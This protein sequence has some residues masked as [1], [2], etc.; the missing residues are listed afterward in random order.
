MKASIKRASIR[1]AKSVK[2][3]PMESQELT[4]TSEP[5]LRPSD[6]SIR[7]RAYYNTLGLLQEVCIL[8]GPVSVNRIV[9]QVFGMAVPHHTSLTKLTITRGKLAPIVLVEIGKLL[10]LS[11]L[12]EICLDDTHVPQKNYATL[13]QNGHLLRNLSLKRCKLNDNTCKEIAASIEIG[14]PGATLQTLELSS[15]SISDEGAVAFANVLRRNRYLLHLNLSGNYITDEGAAAILKV[16]MEFPMTQNEILQKRRNFINFAKR[17]IEIYDR[18]LLEMKISRQ[19]PD[20]RTRSNSRTKSLRSGTGSSK[21]KGSPSKKSDK[22]IPDTSLE[23]P[24][25]PHKMGYSHPELEMKARETVGE[26]FDPF[27]ADQTVL[28]EN[29]FYCVGN[30]FFCSLNLAYNNLEYSSVKLINTVL[31]YQSKVKRSPAAPGL[32]RISF[33]GNLVPQYC[34][35]YIFIELWLQNAI[36]NHL[37]RTTTTIH[38]KRVPGQRKSSG[39]LL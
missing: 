1:S 12:V 2:V 13:L 24:E 34:E 25:T 17:K 9:I 36:S 20:V 31:E 6:D 7:I 37:P 3:R 15:N 32:M 19:R 10:P 11:H 18:L 38:K 27:D 14:T 29:T 30:M 21:Q 39:T 16:L 23:L 33:E 35:E 22:K 5:V 26:F 8:G 28:K 4:P